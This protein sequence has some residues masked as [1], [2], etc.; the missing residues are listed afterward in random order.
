MSERETTMWEVAIN[1]LDRSPE[2]IAALTDPSWTS[3]QCGKS[4][5]CCDICVPQEG[6]HPH[7]VA[8]EIYAEG[9]RSIAF[10]I[11]SRI[12]QAADIIESLQHAWGCTARLGDREV[13]FRY[14]VGGE[15]EVWA[16]LL[17]LKVP[18][19]LVK[20]SRLDS[21]DTDV[22]RDVQEKN[23][24]ARRRARKLAEAAR[25]EREVKRKMRANR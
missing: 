22:F 16:E 20:V 5:E 7:E 24:A 13:V 19:Y 17:R 8:G 21:S 2:A 14:A 6:Y 3:L 15:R 25:A 11:A 9:I 1:L 23:L 18:P 10:E 4:E 12:Q